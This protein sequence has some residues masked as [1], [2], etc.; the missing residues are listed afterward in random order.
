MGLKTGLKSFLVRRR[1]EKRN[2]KDKLDEIACEL[3]ELSADAGPD[4]NNSYY[5]SPHSRRP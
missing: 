4:I 3:Y 1:M 5:F 2:K